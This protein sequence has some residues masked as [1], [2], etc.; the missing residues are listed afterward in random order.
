MLALRGRH[1]PSRLPSCPERACRAEQGAH[2]SVVRGRPRREHKW[3][4]GEV[5]TGSGQSTGTPALVADSSAC[6]VEP[7]HQQP[8]YQRRSRR[9]APSCKQAELVAGRP[10]GRDLAIGDPRGAAAA[11]QAAARR[12]EGCRTG[13]M[14]ASHDGA[15][16]HI[17]AVRGGVL[18]LVAQIHERRTQARRDLP[19]GLRTGRA[20]PRRLTVQDDPR[21]LCASAAATAAREGRRGLQRTHVRRAGAGLPGGGGGSPTWRPAPLDGVAVRSRGERSRADIFGRPAPAL[22]N[23]RRLADSRTRAHD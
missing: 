19:K 14:P 4:R 17:V 6:G 18:F 1:L 3:R 10:N 22:V 11:A 23:E 2:F 8:G 20:S 13:L 21:D 7:V 9:L 15:H 16:N 12:R 5:A